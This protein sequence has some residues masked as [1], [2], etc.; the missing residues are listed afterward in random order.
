MSDGPG[1]K[2]G[3]LTPE[4]F[5]EKAR[6]CFLLARTMAPDGEQQFFRNLI[7]L[8]HQLEDEA[9]KLEAGSDADKGAEEPA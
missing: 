2:N 3:M 6:Q 4:Y 8:G 1:K 5:R 9:A 7:L